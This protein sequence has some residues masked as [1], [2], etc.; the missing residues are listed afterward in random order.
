MQ[1]TKLYKQ[2]WQHPQKRSS[3]TVDKRTLTHVDCKKLKEE[4][5]KNK[6]VKERPTEGHT[7]TC[8]SLDI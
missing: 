3:E 4:E 8:S 6:E 1:N 2:G 7:D 5:K